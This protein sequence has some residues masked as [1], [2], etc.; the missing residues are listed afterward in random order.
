MAIHDSSCSVGSA[1]LQG[2]KSV[3]PGLTRSKAT[4][5][6]DSIATV[7]NVQR[8]ESQAQCIWVLS[9]DL[10]LWLDYGLTQQ[11]QFPNSGDR[12]YTDDP[13]LW[14]FS[15]D[16]GTD[17]QDCEFTFIGDLLT[18]MYADIPTCVPVRCVS[19][20]PCF[21]NVH[22]VRV[23]D[24]F[25]IAGPC[26]NI[27]SAGMSG[28]FDYV[29]PVLGLITPC[30]S[31]SL[32]LDRLS[33]GFRSVQYTVVRHCRAHRRRRTGHSHFGFARGLCIDIRV[34]R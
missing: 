11:I 34:K 3:W 32:R 16:D 19:F 14:G 1:V 33:M 28:P 13:S 21:P 23:V 18:R 6:S 7:C 25:A 12:R 9:P 24:W 15:L 8:G 29:G 31:F 4:R 22:K 5:L 30:L 20:L 27:S 17:D 26:R 10:F 2:I